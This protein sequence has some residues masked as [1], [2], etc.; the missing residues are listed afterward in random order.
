MQAP[1]N[2]KKDVQWPATRIKGR[3]LVLASSIWLAGLHSLSLAAQELETPRAVRDTFS[4]NSGYFSKDYANNIDYAQ[5]VMDVRSA[6]SRLALYGYD[7]YADR[8]NGTFSRL[9]YLSGSGLL[10]SS[11][12][13]RV[14]YHE[15]GHASRMVAMGSSASLSSCY[16]RACPAPRDF[17]GYAGS[18]VF[19]FKGGYARNEGGVYR[20]NASSGKA[21]SNIM[22][23]G[24]VNNE[25]Q[26]TD[27][28]DER[29]FISG[30]GIVFGR[31]LVDN[32]A[33]A[34]YGIKGPEGDIGM[35][36]EE[37]RFK[38][39]D[40]K[41]TEDDLRNTN[42]LSLISGSTYTFVRSIYDFSVSGKV[43]T[44]PWTIGGFLVPN[45]YNY[46]S[47]RGITRKWVSGYSQLQGTGIESQGNW[48]A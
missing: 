40:K 27:K 26:V 13:I 33:I 24:G 2:G 34:S 37:Y 36:A 7:K 22:L 47:S 1:S 11:T 16:D 21:V 41:I 12:G 30:S 6:T 28:S 48:C 3:Q 45:Q 25:M 18:Q 38:G 46:I 31:G 35:M 39:V 17:F 10:N 42:M 20:A 8:L 29:H 4:I 44:K 9:A 14:T 19:N 32:L 15:W 23:G 5:F 43:E